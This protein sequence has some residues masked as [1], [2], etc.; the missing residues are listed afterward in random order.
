M[1]QIPIF[2]FHTWQ[3]DTY[4]V[5]PPGGSMLLAG[6]MH[7]MGIYG[8]I[9]FVLPLYSL[10]LDNLALPAI[11]LSVIGIIYASIIALRQNDLKRLI[12]YVSIAHVGLMAVGSFVLNTSALQGVIPQMISHRINVVGLFI[13]IDIL[14]RRFNS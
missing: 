11:I 4:T 14:E 5:A 12:A 10:V 6:L 8:I 1:V 13:I 2:P 9:R 7:K 3:P